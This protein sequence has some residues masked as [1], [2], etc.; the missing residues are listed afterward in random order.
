MDSVTGR[1]RDL[2]T[3]LEKVEATDREIRE[4]IVEAMEETGATEVFLLLDDGFRILRS[5][6]KPR[7]EKSVYVED[8]RDVID[9]RTPKTAKRETT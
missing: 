4:D 3:Q 2:I 9:C 6:R 8:M 1:L 5:F 7:G